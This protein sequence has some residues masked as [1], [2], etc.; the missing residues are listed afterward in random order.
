MTEEHVTRLIMAW[1][2]GQ[3]WQILHYDYPGSGTGKPIRPTGSK[4][5]NAGSVT[6]DI[7]AARASRA[8][9]FEDKDRYDLGD[10]RKCQAIRSDPMLLAAIA[11]AANVPVNHLAFGLGMPLDSA[12]LV[13]DVPEGIDFI[14]GASAEGCH[15]VR[16]AM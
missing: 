6:A 9:W 5:K 4:A 2:S 12:L 16:G 15:A 13:P 14:V 8:L 7:L 3:G 11:A 10:V 1:L